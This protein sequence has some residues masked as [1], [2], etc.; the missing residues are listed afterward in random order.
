LLFTSQHRSGFRARVFPHFSEEKELISAGYP[1]ICWILKQL[2][3][4][5]EVDSGGYL[6]QIRCFLSSHGKALHPTSTLSRILAFTSPQVFRT[7]PRFPW[8]MFSLIFD[9]V[10]FLYS[11]SPEMLLSLATC[12]YSARFQIARHFLC[13]SVLLSDRSFSN[14][15]KSFVA[16][17]WAMR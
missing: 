6:P 2:F 5:V 3:T 15:Q 12:S 8:L 7:G 11:P 10:A 1:L 13:Y 14:L 4:E 16:A 9:C 17:F